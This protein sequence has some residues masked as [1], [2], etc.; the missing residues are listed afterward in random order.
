MGRVKGGRTIFLVALCC[1][2][3]GQLNAQAPAGEDDVSKKTTTTTPP[4]ETTKPTE[5]TTTTIPPTTSTAPPTTTTPAPAPVP[6]T[7]A[8]P[9]VPSWPKNE[10]EWNVTDAKT[11]ITC[12]KLNGAFEVVVPYHGNDSKAING[13]ILN[14]IVE[15]PIKAE[16]TGDCGVVNGTHQTITLTWDCTTHDLHPNTLTFHF[17][18]NHNSSTVD[19]ISSGKWALVEISGNISIDPRFFPHSLENGTQIPIEIKDLATYQASLDHSYKCMAKET[20]KNTKGSGEA[21]KVANLQVEAFGTTPHATS[22][23]AAQECTLDGVTDVVPIAVG[24]SLAGLVVIVL[25]A[26]LFGRR[27]SR[28]RGYQSV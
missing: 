21:V 24:A 5:K 15:I 17:E 20:L 26:Y 28:A 3:V 27:R 11:N 23:N 18:A 12:I 9:F 19:Q 2:L 16:A 10:G 7:T 14:A 8:A 25:I 13:T 4:P 1:A 22:F 6:T